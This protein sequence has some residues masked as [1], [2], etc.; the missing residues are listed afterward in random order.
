VRAHRLPDEH[1]WT[2]KGSGFDY[3]GDVTGER[4]ARQ[5][6]WY[7]GAAAVAPLVDGQNTVTREE[8]PHRAEPFF[9][10]PGESM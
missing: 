9:R 5:I 2:L 6:S 1:N 8:V 7:T 10:V 4:I 3:R